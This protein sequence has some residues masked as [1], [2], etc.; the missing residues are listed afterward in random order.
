MGSCEIEGCKRAL[1]SKRYCKPHHYEHV[2]GGDMSPR[3]PAKLPENA[4]CSATGC[5]LPVKAKGLCRK[6]YLR[7]FRNGDTNLR[8]V[9]IP[10]GGPCAVD[11]C[12]KP[13]RA[14]GYCIGHYRRLRLHGNPLG[15]GRTKTEMDRFAEKYRVNAQTGCWEWTAERNRKGYGIFWRNASMTGAHRA[16]YELHVGPIPDGLH[17]LHRC[18]NPPCVNP[19]HLFLGTNQDNVDDRQRKGRWKVNANKTEVRNGF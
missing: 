5:D 7:N 3:R 6:H 17:V 15:S 1:Y 9:T 12:D 19:A 16:S 8:R 10:T 11:G 13:A 14:T 4:T 2:R 18:D